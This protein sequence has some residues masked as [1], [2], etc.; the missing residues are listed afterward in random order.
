M[1]QQSTPPEASTAQ[2]DAS[3]TAAIKLSDD[4]LDE[5]LAPIALYPDPLLAQ[6]IPAATFVDDIQEAH[7][8]LK[9]STDD[10]LI[11]K[12]D[13]DVSVKSVAHYPPVLKKMA[14]NEDWT[15]TV[16]Q[17]YISQPADITKSLQRLRSEATNVGNLVTTPQQE[18]IVK[19]DII[20]IEPAQPEVIYV[21]EY[22]PETVYVE[23]TTYVEPQD[24]GVSTGTAIAVGALA[25]GAGL[26]IGSWLNRDYDYYGDY[27]SGPYYHGW[28]GGGWVGVNSAYVNTN[29][30]RNVYVNDSYRN[31]NTN[32]NVI[33]HNVGNNYRNDLTRNAAVRNQRETNAG[34]DR[35]LKRQNGPNGNGPDLGDR[36]RG[37]LGGNNRGDL[38]DRNNLGGNNRGDNNLG[39]NRP[40]PKTNDRNRGDL[41]GNNPNRGR[42]DLGGNRQNLGDRNNSARNM[43]HNRGGSP[44]RGG[45]SQ[46]QNQGGNHQ[47]QNA[48]PKQ[49]PQRSAPQRSG[50]GGG[51]GG[52]KRG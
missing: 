51:G 39:G 21:P 47:R 20:R 10:N 42:N 43:D 32:R 14:E 22:N 28:S 3:T 52:R 49:Q 30:N 23:Q 48:S 33:N 17:V 12:Q 50:G 41:G 18:V 46:R 11:A 7:K 16:G 37:D 29:I 6:I 44:N 2:N 9:G 38:G 25:F 5:L 26:A 40:Q 31:I 35:Q 1:P 15:T 19:D 34:V 13:W 27:G 45:G 24:E 4:E 8:T 36:N